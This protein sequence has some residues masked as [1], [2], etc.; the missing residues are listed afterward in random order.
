MRVGACMHKFISPKYLRCLDEQQ[1]AITFARRVLSLPLLVCDM[2]LFPLS[3]R[4]SVSILLC[5]GEGWH[6]R[7]SCSDSY[8]LGM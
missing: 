3:L 2:R 4:Q 6:C 8:K 5:A 1:H 7:C